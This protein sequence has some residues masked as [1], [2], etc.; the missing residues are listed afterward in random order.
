MALK[1]NSPRQTKRSTPAPK[2]RTE[3]IVDN[4]YQEAQSDGPKTHGDHLV[5]GPENSQITP[6]D[7]CLFGGVPGVESFKLTRRPEAHFYTVKA[8]EVDHGGEQRKCVLVEQW[9]FDI[10]V[11]PRNETRDGNDQGEDQRGDRGGAFMGEYDIEHD[12]CGVDHGKLVEELHAIWS[13]KCQ[14]LVNGNKRVFF[15]VGPNTCISGWNGRGS[16]L[17]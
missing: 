6:I 9:I 15:F 8:P 14:Y 3:C 1:Q 13:R 11:V 2:R 7:P 17:R 16:C 5:H 10:M 4:P 12:A